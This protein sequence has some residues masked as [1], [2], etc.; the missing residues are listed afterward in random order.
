MISNKIE[1]YLHVVKLHSAK[2]KTD[3]RQQRNKNKFKN[4][5]KPNNAHSYA[6]N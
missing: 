4:K 2:G 6:E 3:H 5:N 1:K